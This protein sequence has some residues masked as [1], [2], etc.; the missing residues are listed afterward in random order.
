MAVFM[1]LNS[2]EALRINRPSNIELEQIALD[3]IDRKFDRRDL[4]QI[5]DDPLCTSNE[6]YTKHYKDEGKTDYPVD[7]VVP[8]FGVDHEIS[9]TQEN[10]SAAEK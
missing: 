3:R 1:L 10:I 5:Q 7:Y 8:N 9:S 6:C 4:I 2:S